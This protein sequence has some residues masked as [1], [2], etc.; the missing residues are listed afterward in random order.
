MKN[1]HEMDINT[2]VRSVD[3]S[4]KEV[5]ELVRRIQIMRANSESFNQAIEKQSEKDQETI[6]HLRSFDIISLGT[7]KRLKK[8]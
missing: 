4:N 1:L 3:F 2:L 7:L 5:T 6:R 8:E